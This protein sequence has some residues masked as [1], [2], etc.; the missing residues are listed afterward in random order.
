M[1]VR[2]PTLPEF[3]QFSRDVAPAAQ[4]V[5]MA[6]ANARLTREHVDAYIAPIFA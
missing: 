3:K 5:L 1:T 6:R 4:A 2:I